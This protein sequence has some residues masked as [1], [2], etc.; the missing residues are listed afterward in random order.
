MEM[1][2][3]I[4]RE[5]IYNFFLDLMSDQNGDLNNAQFTFLKDEKNEIIIRFWIEDSKDQKND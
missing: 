1:G 2:H 3:M 5:E 4:D